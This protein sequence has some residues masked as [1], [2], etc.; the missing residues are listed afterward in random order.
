MVEV[1]LYF[2]SLDGVYQVGHRL[3]MP[4]PQCLNLIQQLHTIVCGYETRSEPTMKTDSGRR[5]GSPGAC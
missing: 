5:Q 4:L 1:D 2:V 3:K